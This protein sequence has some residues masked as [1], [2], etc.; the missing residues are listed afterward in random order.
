[1]NWIEMEWNGKDEEEGREREG[2]EWA[3]YS[4]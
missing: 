3:M 4:G 2:G 1:M